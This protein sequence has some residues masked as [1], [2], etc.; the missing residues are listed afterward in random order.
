MPAQH[1]REPL[2]SVGVPFYDAHRFVGGALEVVVPDDGSTDG[3]EDMCRAL[4]AQ[5]RRVRYGSHP[6]NCGSAADVDA[7]AAR[8]PRVTQP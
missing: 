1:E 4:A 2:V 7:V 8:G 6:V 5:D 3:T